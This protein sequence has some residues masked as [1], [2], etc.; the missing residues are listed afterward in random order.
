M[1]L[2]Q[3]LRSDE[4]MVNYVCFCSFRSTQ[5]S[6]TPGHVVTGFISTVEWDLA[7]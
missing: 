1:T 3:G 2:E 5:S 6:S 7:Q 4:D